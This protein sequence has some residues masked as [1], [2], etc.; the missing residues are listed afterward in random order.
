MKKY[1][2]G[3]RADVKYDFSANINPLG[4]PPNV[5]QA[6]INSIDSA[7]KY[8]DPECMELTEKIAEKEHTK[9][10]NIVC[11]NGAADLIYRIVSV[12]KPCNAVICSPTF[13]EYE[14]AL[15]ENKCRI[16][17]FPLSQE[18]EFLCDDAIADTLTSD[19]DMLIMCNPNNPTGKVIPIDLLEKICSICE[20]NNIFFLCD[21]CF[22][23][24]VKNSKL[25]TAGRFINS[26]MI[27]LK[28]FT[29][30][31]AM[32]GI[33]LG[34]A[35]FGSSSLG[36]NVRR[37][38]QFWSVSSIAQAAGIAALREKD[39]VNKTIELIEKERK[40]LTE[41]L[42]E[43]GFIVFGSDVNYILFYC[44]LPLDKILIY[45]GIAIRNCENFDGLGNGYF[46]IAVRCHEEN[47]MFIETIKEC[48]NG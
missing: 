30:I 3:G 2:H 39:F 6:I 27:I 42:R 21:E 4:M 23:D 22:M 15:C 33:R 47:L 41:C 40:F 31:Y 14:K 5:K 13:S 45:K 20:K 26:R 43:L 19:T 11:G 37:S 25:L 7:Q 17:K 44:G 48:I 34:Y 12:I 29:K 1:E 35:V 16:K 46:R 8:P 36:E 18:R 24:F 38:G 9:A 28:A 32:P 10:E